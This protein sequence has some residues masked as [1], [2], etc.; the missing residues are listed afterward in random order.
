[1]NQL[2]KLNIHMHTQLI[3]AIAC[4]K[5]SSTD[6]I[7]NDNTLSQE[8]RP[9]VTDLGHGLCAVYL[10]DEGNHFSY[11]QNHH[12]ADIKAEPT[13]LHEIA[14]INLSKLAQEKLRIVQEGAVHGLLL[15]GQFEASLMLLDDLW[16]DT[17]AHYTPNGAIVAIPTR[18]VLAFCDA[19]SLPGI[20]ELNQLVKRTIP[21]AKHALTAKLYYRQ[22]GQ[23]LPLD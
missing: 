18:D 4:I 23:W 7:E 20:L 14:L 2:F 16:D 15:D 19:K 13:G 6:D 10:I 22:N 1:M 21:K 17:L 5:I 11:V 3:N 9:V 8:Q 12:L